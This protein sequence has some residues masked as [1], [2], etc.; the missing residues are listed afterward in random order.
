MMDKI[1][2]YIVV[3]LLIAVGV[4]K[5]NSMVADHYQA[6]VKAE[7]KAAKESR[8]AWHAYAKAEEDKRA[9]LNRQLLAIGASDRKINDKL[10]RVA[11]DLQQLKEQNPAVTVWAD[12]P[13]PVDVLRLR[14]EQSTSTPS[15]PSVPSGPGAEADGGRSGT[16]GVRREESGHA[17]P[18]DGAGSGAVEVQP[19]PDGD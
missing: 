15:A 14:L 6:P 10:N 11:Y 9:E 3:A 19:T 7:L 17:E 8:D 2:G 4:W 12:T 1:V 13:I 18:G 5:L 16:S